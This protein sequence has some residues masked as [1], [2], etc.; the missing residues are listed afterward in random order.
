ML[1]KITSLDREEDYSLSKKG[2]HFLQGVCII[3]GLMLYILNG[4][5]I[6][7]EELYELNGI[8]TFIKCILMSV[9]GGCLLM[10]CITDGKNCKVYNYTWWLG[11][12]AGVLLLIHCVFEQEG[13]RGDI[14]NWLPELLCFGIIQEYFF[15]RMYGKADCH[16]FVACAIIECALGMGLKAFLIH[17]LLA[18]GLLAGVQLVRRNIGKNGNLKHPVPFLPYITV[19]FWLM[20]LSG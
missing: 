20:C 8:G 6:C 14:R 12:G 2:R 17:M 1:L 19:S 7:S 9:F 3:N 11:G 4:M 13:M 15:S 10:A 5:S 18:F 16:A